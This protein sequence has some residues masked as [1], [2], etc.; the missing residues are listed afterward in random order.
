MDQTM[1]AE[2]PPNRADP[3]TVTGRDDRD[4]GVEVGPGWRL[5]AISCRRACLLSE[6]SDGTCR[7]PASGPAAIPAV[8]R[9][10]L[11][12][13]LN[14]VKKCHA[15][16][17][18]P[19]SKM[20]PEKKFTLRPVDTPFLGPD[21]ASTGAAENAAAAREYRV[22]GFLGLSVAK[23]AARLATPGGFDPDDWLVPSELFRFLTARD[24]K[25]LKRVPSAVNLTNPDPD[26]SAVPVVG[27]ERFAQARSA[28]WKGLLRPECTAVQLKGVAGTG[29]SSLIRMLADEM[30]AM[31]VPAR[32]QAH[33]LVSLNTEVFME[34]VFAF[35]ESAKTRLRNEMADRRIIW[36]IDEAS[37]LVA[38]GETAALDNLLLFIDQGAK[39]ILL[40]DQAHLLEKRE[41]FMRRLSP[42]YLP[43]AG[44]EE[45]QAIVTSRAEHLAAETGLWI[46][47]EALRSAVDLSY[48]SIFAQPHAAVTLLGNTVA[49][50]ELTGEKEVTGAHVEQELRA[51]F[52]QGTADRG[53]PTTLG[54]VVDR[55]RAEGFR[56]HDGTLKEFSRG[57]LRALRRRF[58]PGRPP[59][60]VWSCAFTGAPAVGK[61]MLAGIVGRM[62]TGTE[63][64][65]QRID[66]HYYQSDHAIQ[67]LVGSPMSYVGYGEGGVLQNFIKQN[68]DGVLIFKRPERGHPNVLKILDG[69]L[70][71][72]FTAGDGQRLP[73]G[74]LMVFVTTGA[75]ARDCRSSVGFGTDTRRQGLALANE[76]NDIFPSGLEVY[77]LE[78][79]EPAALRNILR[80]ELNRYARAE[81]VSIGVEEAVLDFLLEKV[82]TRLEG[83]RGVLTAYRQ[84]IEPLLDEQLEGG[85]DCP[86][87]TLYLDDRRQ[88]VCRSDERPPATARG[89]GSEGRRHEKY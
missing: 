28:A 14:L 46:H 70:A 10:R 35:E 41:A 73:T 59:G 55:V 2:T 25:W 18:W 17:R 87:L 53:L 86:R 21:A 49:A 23:A 62:I 50:S 61:N 42:V 7:T 68:P 38:R 52:S 67:S 44:R 84:S 76:F 47:S 26:R 3:D 58:R 6:Q 5:D 81:G 75:G 32:L 63:R 82:N 22:V 69:I 29:K 48:G 15:W 45:V 74:G 9:P 60:P 89:S 40:S 39:V 13:I 77:L 71:G 31:R 56:G 4:L 83:A 8:C 27:S 19:L 78:A 24:A 66:C 20:G 80:L 36:V 88:I 43:P 72:E 51:M 37:R 33:L 12:D 11:Q 79:L 54:D 85:E 65:V 16:Q 34:S 64:K 1:M 30:I 57:L